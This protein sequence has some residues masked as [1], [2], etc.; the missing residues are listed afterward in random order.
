MRQPHAKD[1]EERK[2][3]SNR[4]SHGPQTESLQVELIQLSIVAEEKRMVPT[5]LPPCRCIDAPIDRWLARR[6]PYFLGH[7]EWKADDQSLCREYMSG[8]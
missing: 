5:T 7:F 6:N 3:K 2:Q 4:Q 8:E 1:Q